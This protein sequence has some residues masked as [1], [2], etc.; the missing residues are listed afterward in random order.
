VS[1]ETVL[2]DAQAHDARFYLRFGFCGGH[3]YAVDTPCLLFSAF[4]SMVFITTL[5]VALIIKS[6]QV[7]LVAIL[8]GL[9]L[10]LKYVYEQHL[11]DSWL[12]RFYHIKLTKVHDRSVYIGTIQA[13]SDARY[14]RYLDTMYVRGKSEKDL[15]NDLGMSL[16]QWHH[17]MRGEASASVR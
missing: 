14:K 5:C 12:G 10:V 4:C 8:L 11:T 15:A 13:M 16:T 9:L 2:P 1:L 3:W 7:G 17:L 6:P